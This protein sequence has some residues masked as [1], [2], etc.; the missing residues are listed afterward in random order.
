MNGSRP[1]AARVAYTPVAR[2]ADA[3]AAVYEAIRPS[4]AG[5]TQSRFLK[6]QASRVQASRAAD[7]RHDSRT[8]TRDS[9]AQLFN[10]SD[11]LPLLSH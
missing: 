8:R 3:P 9:E 6:A 4:S 2:G 10:L 11:R 7:T 5:P 1:G